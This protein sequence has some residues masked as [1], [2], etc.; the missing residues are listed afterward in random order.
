LQYQVAIE[1]HLF[2]RVRDLF[3][4]DATVTLYGLTNPCFEGSAAPSAR[5]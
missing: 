5:R 3:D 1:D 2:G 4:L